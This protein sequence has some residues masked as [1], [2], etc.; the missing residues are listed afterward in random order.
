M[1]WSGWPPMLLNGMCILDIRLQVQ[2]QFKKMGVYCALAFSDPGY[3]KTI[4]VFLSTSNQS[5]F[6][7]IKMWP[8]KLNKAHFLDKRV[9][10]FFLVCFRILKNVAINFSKLYKC[11]EI[12]KLLWNQIQPTVLRFVLSLFWLHRPKLNRHP[13][14]LLQS[15]RRRKIS[16]TQNRES[17]LLTHRHCT[18]I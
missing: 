18:H 8:S 9:H 6:H 12:I 13:S 2:I 14:L 3:L 11:T 16:H 5:I 10:P 15:R 17:G 4:W 7:A 1:K